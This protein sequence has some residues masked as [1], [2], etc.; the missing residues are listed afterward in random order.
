MSIQEYR[1]IAFGWALLI[2]FLTVFWFA[3]LRRLSVVLKERLAATR[4]HQ[5]FS[6]G[7]PGVFLFIFRGEFKQTGDERLSAVC[8]RLRQL[9]YGYLG[10]VIAYFVFI[11]IFRPRI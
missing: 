10:S 4:S 9:L 1:Y 7:L 2:L 3:T 5:S 6:G 8:R 11:V